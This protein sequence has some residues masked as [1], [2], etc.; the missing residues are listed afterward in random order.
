M[1]KPSL[2][3]LSSTESL[4]RVNYRFVQV[5]HRHGDRSP[6]KNYCEGTDKEQAEIDTWKSLVSCQT[7][8]K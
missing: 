1:E 8:L 4:N 3:T 7:I 6:L 2:I 5:F